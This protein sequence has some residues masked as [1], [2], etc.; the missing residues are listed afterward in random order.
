MKKIQ[1]KMASI[2]NFILLSAVYL[3]GVGIT[4]IIARVFGK[5]FLIDKNKRKSNFVTFKKTNDLERMF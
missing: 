1:Q 4:S 5:N 3:V 2:F